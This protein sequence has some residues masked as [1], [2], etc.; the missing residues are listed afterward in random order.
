MKPRKITLLTRELIIG[1]IEG[2][3]SKSDAQIVEELINS[4]DRDFT[5]FS[6]LYNSYKEMQDVKLEKT[7]ASLIQ[8]AKQTLYDD[9]YRYEEELVPEFPPS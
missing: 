3:L 7:P 9:F 2:K 4:S 6:T 1:F 8:K 5:K